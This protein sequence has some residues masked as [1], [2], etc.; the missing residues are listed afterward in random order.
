MCLYCRFGQT[1][2]W[3]GADNGT[4]TGLQGLEH[5]S[6]LCTDIL[7][8]AESHGRDLGTGVELECRHVCFVKVSI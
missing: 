4:Y 8:G 1:I 5:S 6:L 7:P 3:G 2:G